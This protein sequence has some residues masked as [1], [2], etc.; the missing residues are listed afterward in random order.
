MP[1]KNVYKDNLYETSWLGE[2]VDIDDPNKNGRIKVRVYGKFDLISTP[3]IPWAHPAN[4]STGGSSSGGSF[5]SVPKLGSIVS[6]KFD[7]G[8]LYHPEYFFHQKISEEVKAEIEGSYTNAHVIIYDTITEGFLKIFFTEEKGMMIDYKESQI[9]IK[10]DK[11][12]VIKNASGDGEIEMLDDG[13]LNITQANDINIETKT[14]VNIKAVNVTV[15]HSN[16]IEL[17][18]GA[19]EKLV[20]GDSFLTLFN[21]H[22]HIGN[23]GAP[24]S[25]SIIPMTP[26]QHLSGRGAIPVVRTK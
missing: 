1:L 15:E 8:N 22:V 9:N 2:V 26:I 10:P 17:G 16:T 14:D 19:S 12:I 4:N 11:S 25:P 3:D 23:L 5:F 7:N 6:V 24:T 13:T 18:K 20:L 21:Q